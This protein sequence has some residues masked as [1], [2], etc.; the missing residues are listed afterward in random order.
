MG[1]EPTNIEWNFIAPRDVTQEPTMG[2][3]EYGG[4]AISKRM[5][6]TTAK[7]TFMLHKKHVWI[8]I[9]N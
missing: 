7:D 9:L 5:A 1:L 8:P 3:K 2:M 6:E 4:L